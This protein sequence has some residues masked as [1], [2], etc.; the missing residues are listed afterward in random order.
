MEFKSDSTIGTLA[1]RGAP[2]TAAL[3]RRGRIAVRVACAGWMISLVL[4]CLASARAATDENAAGQSSAILIT[5]PDRLFVTPNYPARLAVF[6]KH[7]G[8]HVEDVSDSPQLQWQIGAPSMIGVDAAEVRSLAEGTTTLAV[9]WGDDIVEVPVSSS[10][11]SPLSF[12]R[13]IMSTL[14]RSGCNLG[15]CHGNLHGKGGFRLSLRGDDPDFDHYRIAKEF[16][17]RR[18]DPWSA[19]SSLLLLKGTASIAHQGGRRFEPDSREH[20]WMTQ[21]IEAGASLSE[22]PELTRLWVDPPVQRVVPNQ[23]S[24]RVVVRAQFSDGQIR[25]VTR[26]ARIEPSV[27]SGIEVDAVGRV[28]ATQAIDVSLGVTYLSGRAASRVVFLGEATTG[29]S[30]E[31]VADHPIDR[32]VEQQCKELLVGLAPRADDWSLI[33]RLYLVTVGRLPTP[34]ETVAFVEDRDPQRIYRWVDQ[35]LSDPDFD[36]AWALRWS[37]LIRNEEKVMSPRGAEL[38]HDWL[39][40]QTAADRPMRDWIAELVSSTG[41]TYDN[42]PA[43]FHRTHRDPFVAA[44]STAQ[45]FLGLRLQCAKCHNH[46]FD[47][48]RQDD[49]YGLAAYFTTVE[50]KQIENKPKDA[51]DK[52]VITGDEIISLAERRPEIQHPGRSRTVG[53]SALQWRSTEGDAVQNLAEPDGASRL[54]PSLKVEPSNPLEAFA[55]WLT[56]DNPQLDIN[57]ANRIWYQYFG[58]GIVEPPDDFRDSNPPSNPALLAF[59]ASELRASDYSLKAIT[60]AILTSETF[61]RGA[62]VESNDVSLLS[63]A[64]YFA[65]YPVRRLSAEVL[66]DAIGDVTGV[67]SKLRTGAEEDTA[68]LTKAMRMAGVPRK[69]GFLTAFGK[70][71]RLLVCECERSNQVSLGQ[72]LALING[73]EVREKLTSPTNRISQWLLNTPRV[74]PAAVAL[75]AAAAL[76]DELTASSV[77]NPI[78]ETH[79]TVETHQMVEELFLRALCRRPSDRESQRA[80]ESIESATDRRQALEDLV[81]AL[82]NS[83]EFILLR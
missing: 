78:V 31:W 76:T 82:L 57:L 49:Y 33:R 35:L 29:A 11:D 70:P 53:P 25:D 22:S 20:A 15:V 10:S 60:R 28:V 17:Q 50:R 65:G 2:W 54:A 27:P 81:W 24:T 67:P 59:L 45:V 30:T 51:L 18:I 68:T 77:P 55:N 4:V 63:M 7:P 74:S 79:P 64:P 42:P 69:P 32:L 61:A 19:E 40:A 23:K 56:H 9:R 36:Y 1:P 44:E 21:W 13:E 12:S 37:D 73:T 3:T 52:H 14:T 5:V 41:S 72:S 6:R 26:W 43:S 80:I 48:W 39:R 83:K 75:P 38:L 8:G 66:M 71:N 47:V 58:R 46:P 62:A 34:D 16:G